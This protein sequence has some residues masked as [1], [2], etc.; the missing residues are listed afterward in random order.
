VTNPTTAATRNIDIGA[1]T[2]QAQFEL[3]QP[4]VARI[5]FRVFTDIISVVVKMRHPT[6]CGYA[7]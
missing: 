7:S 3:T 1:P 5:F 2:R 4:V 6:L